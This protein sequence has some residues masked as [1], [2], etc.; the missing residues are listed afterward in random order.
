[1]PRRC[2]CGAEDRELGTEHYVKPLIKFL[3]SK[4]ALTPQLKAK[5]W[6]YRFFQGRHA[7]S[8]LACV[9]CIR[10]DKEADA[11]MRH[12]KSAAAKAEHRDE[13]NFY[14]VLCS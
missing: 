5:G 3:G 2:A 11:M 12:Y 14:A 6:E 4:D 1:M 8:R 9:P 10:L 13:E 7:M